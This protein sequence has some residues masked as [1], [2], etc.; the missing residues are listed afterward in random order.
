MCIDFVDFQG[1][2]MDPW[3]KMNQ[4]VGKN[5]PA[6]DIKNASIFDTPDRLWRG[7]VPAKTLGGHGPNICIEIYT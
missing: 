4:N 1:P 6:T 7:A 2:K 3:E 5:Y